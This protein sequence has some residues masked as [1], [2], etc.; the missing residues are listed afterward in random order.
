ML[1]S[2]D[3]P[4]LKFCFAITTWASCN[5]YHGTHSLAFRKIY[6][7]C[8][9]RHQSRCLIELGWFSSQTGAK[10]LRPVL[11]LF[12][13]VIFCRLRSPTVHFRTRM[14][15][16][17][18]WIDQTGPP[19]HE[20]TKLIITKNEK[21]M[22]STCILSS[23]THRKKFESCSRSLPKLPWNTISLRTDRDLQHCWIQRPPLLSKTSYRY[24]IRSKNRIETFTQ[25]IDRIGGHYLIRWSYPLVYTCVHG[26]TLLESNSSFRNLMFSAFLNLR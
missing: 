16:L 3:F 17:M 20:C 12:R 26:A 23:H 4:S 7:C 11:K 15:V 22:N 9:N 13:S 1:G 24:P 10:C 8:F 5:Q 6:S 2:H 25:S 21:I 18:T 19:L 14:Q